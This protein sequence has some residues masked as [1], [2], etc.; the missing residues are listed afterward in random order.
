[1]SDTNK[2]PGYKQQVAQLEE[3]ATK[4]AKAAND[5]NVPLADALLHH[6]PQG[7]DLSVF[8]GG[9]A[10]VVQGMIDRS[11]ISKEQ[12]VPL[13]DTSKGYLAQLRDH[14][15]AKAALILKPAQ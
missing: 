5:G 8:Y 11:K 2:E 4:Y 1:M 13:S 9:L 14:Y 15:A 12:E 10:L 3:V 7:T 6:L